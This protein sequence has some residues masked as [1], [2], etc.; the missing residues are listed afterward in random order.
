[1]SVPSTP[2]L[3]PSSAVASP[4]VLGTP[5]AQPN[6]GMSGPDTPDVMGMQ[7]LG[8]PATPATPNALDMYESGE[9]GLNNV[10]PGYA[11]EE[12]ME[13]GVQA[14][15]QGQQD[16]DPE[17]N[18]ELWGTT[19]KISEC[20]SRF[21]DFLLNFRL[22]GTFNETPLYL[23]EFVRIRGSQ[24]FIMNLRAS[25][26]HDYVATRNLYTQVKV[27]PQ[28]LIPIIDAVV[29]EEYARRF[30]EHN[31]L[32][33]RIQTRIYDLRQVERMRHLEPSHIDQLLCLKGMV[34]RCSPVIPDLR[35]AFFRCFSCGATHEENLDRNHIEE[36]SECQQCQ[37]KGSM[38][39]IHNRCLFSDKQLIRLQETPDE[40]PEGE[41]PCTVNLFA[42]DDLVDMVRPGDRVEVTGIL[43]AMPRRYNPKQRALRAVYKTYIDTVHF[44]R[45]NMAGD[46][47]N[48][49]VSRGLGNASQGDTRGDTITDLDGDQ[50]PTFTEERVEEFR[51]FAE[52]NGGADVS[53]RLVNSFA[54]SIW[55]MDDVKL[56]VLC[57]LF[58]GTM[59]NTRE[60]LRKEAQRVRK[61]AQR[62]R[63]QEFAEGLGV[64]GE[65]GEQ[66]EARMRM[67]EQEAE[68]MEIDEQDK[69]NQGTVKMH[70]RGDIN[71]LLCGD[72]GTSKSQLL[73]F[74]HKLSSRGIYTS[75]KGSSAVGLTASVVR[76]PETR[77]VVLES[78]ALVLSD[79]G[80]CC[81]DE[82]DKMPDMT[83]AILHEAMEQQTVSITRAGIVATLNARTSV[84]A[85]ANPVESRYN[86]RLSVIDNIKL[87]P[88]LLS[89]FDLIYLILDKPNA[90][91]DRRLA[92]HLV[93]LYHVANGEPSTG[94]GVQT[95]SHS[96]L[97]D[98]ILYARTNV[99]PEIDDAAEE[100][101]V[102]GY[103]DMRNMGAGS[104]G[105]G[106]KTITA[107]PRQLESLIRISQALAKMRL[108]TTVTERDVREAIRLMRVATQTAA[109]DPRTGT[110]D[111]DMIATGHAAM[112]RDNV[113]RLAEAVREKIKGHRGKRM[114]TGQLLNS[115]Q[116]DATVP[117]TMEEMEEAIQEIL[118]DEDC[119]IRYHEDTRT[120]IV[121]G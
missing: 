14:D 106:N 112:D 64:L 61:E 39:L 111:M 85:S 23:D 15:E 45:V 31:E 98:Y 81:I 20:V 41:T 7:D 9:S 30:P 105:G 93:S 119:P 120:V 83:R 43:K 70:K 77:E 47:E 4:L 49:E 18:V 56:G 101:L 90:D 3:V 118:E 48:R 8:A 115:I 55:E 40:V 72:P 16:Q 113:S 97:R 104:R 74:V 71:I 28:E 99:A 108:A 69:E 63:R 22:N 32:A 54:P 33:P 79:N 114:T 44:R 80:I 110:I 87:P 10:F 103:L 60:R 51:Q 52:L 21:R 37:K 75:G 117:V 36:P 34:V 86:A 102:Q 29:N 5:H 84:L 92:R 6:M 17:D 57:Q 121:Q 38:E 88:T 73:G 67:D 50:A 78:G 96:F 42:Y 59:Q 116:Q 68:T 1:M 24:R 58:G 62:R 94:T 65:D 26:L 2:A 27:Y 11:L 53:T 13:G 109:T 66:E 107:T 12:G 35:Q 89:R 82:F 91:S 46:A 100:V 76:D 95:V 19:I 25:H